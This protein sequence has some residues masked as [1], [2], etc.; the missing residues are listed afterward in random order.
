MY[1]TIIMS[2]KY[3]DRM[4]NITQKISVTNAFNYY[5]THAVRGYVCPISSGV[6]F[7]V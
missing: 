7:L 2:I 6:I 1:A 3:P 5:S 4:L